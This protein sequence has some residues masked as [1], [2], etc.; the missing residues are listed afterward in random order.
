M[1]AP[2]YLG[3]ER[4]LGTV[5]RETPREEVERSVAQADVICCATT[6]RASRCSTADSCPTTQW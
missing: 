1:T 5:S 6:A 3:A 4:I 2:P